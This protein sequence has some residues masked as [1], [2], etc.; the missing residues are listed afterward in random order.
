MFHDGAMGGLGGAPQ[1]VVKFIVGARGEHFALA[2]D[3]VLLLCQ[4]ER[5]DP[6]VTFRTVPRLGREVIKSE[7]RTH[8]NGYLPA[9]PSTQMCLFQPPNARQSSNV[10]RQ[11]RSREVQIRILPA[12]YTNQ[13]MMARIFSD[14][15]HSAFSKSSKPLTAMMAASLKDAAPHKL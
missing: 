12:I 7:G 13:S 6:P 5:G 8:K 3:R 15:L 11:L 4:F 2:A 1:D 14:A 9:L 10:L